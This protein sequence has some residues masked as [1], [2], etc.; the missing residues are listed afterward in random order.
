M[1][2]KNYPRIYSIAL[3]FIAIFFFATPLQAEISVDKISLNKIDI[4]TLDSPDQLSSFLEDVYQAA[5]DKGIPNFI[6]Y[7]LL[8]IKESKKALGQMSS[9][10]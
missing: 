8:L 3:L 9:S 2:T 4:E 5:L 10:Y 1:Q 6:P 7:S